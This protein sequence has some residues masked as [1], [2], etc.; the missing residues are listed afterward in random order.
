MDPFDSDNCPHVSDEMRGVADAA[1]DVAPIDRTVAVLALAASG[2]PRA[3]TRRRW[4]RHG[5]RPHPAA[6]DRD[7]AERGT[8]S[9]P[10]HL[11]VAK[12][13]APDHKHAA[14]LIRRAL[15]LLAET[16]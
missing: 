14:D 8:S 11:Q 6:G 15:V 13:W 1:R 4:T 10:L 3:F 5:G 12:A 7:D 2:D 16:N 9:K